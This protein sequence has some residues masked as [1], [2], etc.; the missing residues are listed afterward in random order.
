M[1]PL[2]AL[3]SALEDSSVTLQRGDPNRQHPRLARFKKGLD[4]TDRQERRR[5]A[6]LKSQKKGRDDYLKHARNLA[7]LEMDVDQQEDEED[8]A[9][10]T[11]DSDDMDTREAIRVTQGLLRRGRKDQLMLSEWFDEVP[12]DFPHAWVVA[13]VPTG[14]RCLVVAGQGRT[15]QFARGGRFMYQ[16]PSLLPGGNKHQEDAQNQTSLLDCIYEWETGNFY[17]LDI[18]VWGSDTFYDKVSEA[19]FQA[20]AEKLGSVPEIGTKASRNPYPFLSVPTFAADPQSVFGGLSAEFPFRSLDGLLCYH[21]EVHY[22]PGQ[23]TNPLVLWLKAYMAPELM[24]SPVPDSIKATAP[25]DY[26]NASAFIEHYKAEYKA[27]KEEW[28]R[29]KEQ[30]KQAV[31]ENDNNDGQKNMDVQIATSGEEAAPMD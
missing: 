24:N 14:K 31:N 2:D 18:M 19:R 27:R 26:L 10:S 12:R 8:E 17:V 22:L 16:F 23:K 5:Q 25:A 15:R 21:R 6:M 1:D 7:Q 13:A 4:M 9:K 3:T 20:V 29:S 28:K 11:A 30:I